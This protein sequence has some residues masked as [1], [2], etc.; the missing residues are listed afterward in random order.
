MRLSVGVTLLVLAASVVGCAD[1]AERLQPSARPAPG[2]TCPPVTPTPT[3]AAGSPGSTS[4][5]PHRTSARPSSSVS[6]APR[7]VRTPTPVV[8]TAYPPGPLAPFANRVSTTQ[9]VVFVTIDDGWTRD[10]SFPADVRKAGVPI[11]LFLIAGAAKEGYAYFRGLQSLG[12][13]IEDHTVDHARCSRLTYA[14]QRREICTA[15]DSY[16]SVFG[17]RPTLFRP[18]YGDFTTVTRRAAAACGM[19]AVV[20]WDV[21]VNNGRLS[22]ASRSRLRAGDIILMHFTAGIRRDF[23][24]ALAAARAQG[25]TVRR[26]ESYL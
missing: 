21:S 18:P 1:G 23:A 5:G 15:A 11:S 9:R 22:F 17:R 4:P 10:T 26:L 25:F 16:Q 6:A 7:P 14:E 3:P 12:A 19:H 8:P 24:A 13:T 2:P 20:T